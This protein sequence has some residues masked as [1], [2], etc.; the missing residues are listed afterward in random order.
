MVTGFVQVMPLDGLQELGPCG[1]I[2]PGV[3]DHMPKVTFI[4]GSFPNKRFCPFL[5]VL[6]FGQLPPTDSMAELGVL[7]I[8]RGGWGG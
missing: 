7:I 6:A 3:Y 2:Q 1:S 4:G 5:N 8:A